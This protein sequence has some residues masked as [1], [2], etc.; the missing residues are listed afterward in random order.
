MIAEGSNIIEISN[1]I[2][3]I[4]NYPLKKIDKISKNG[5]IYSFNDKENFSL[6]YQVFF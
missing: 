2:F 1:L 6:I 4:K 5:M 3:L